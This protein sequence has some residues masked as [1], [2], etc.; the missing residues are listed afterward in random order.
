[1]DDMHQTNSGIGTDDRAK[2]PK[3]SS[4]LHR[5]IAPSTLRCSRE[6]ATQN[7]VLSFWGKTIR[8]DDSL[9]HKRGVRPMRQQFKPLVHHLLDVAAVAIQL[10]KGNHSLLH[11]EAGD[12]GVAPD[13]LVR[14]YA[15]L[16]SLHDIGKFSK[17]FQA[18]V[19]SLWPKR[20]LGPLQEHGGRP[21]WRNTAIL[22]RTP[23]LQDEFRMLFPNVVKDDIVSIIAAVS[24]H[25]GK[26]PTDNDL[27]IR[28][29]NALHDAQIGRK[30]VSMSY[31]AMQI[32]K[33]F[34]QPLPI[35]E[36]RSHKRIMRWSWF[37]SGFITICDW[38]GSDDIYFRFHESN[39]PIE[40]YWKLANNYAKQ[41]L[42]SKGLI[43]SVPIRRPTYSN[44]SPQIVGRLRPM[45]EFVQKIELANGPQLFILEDT[46]GSGKTEAAIMLAARMM[47]ARKGEGIYFALPTMATANAM[48][49]R[50]DKVYRSLFDDS[51]TPSLALAHG[52]SIITQKLWSM[53]K[54]MRKKS[55]LTNGSKD[56]YS[57][58]TFCAD[59]IADDRRLSLLAEIGAGTIDQAFLAVLP[60][61]FLTLRQ[62]SLAQ[63]I[64]VIDEA[65]CFDAYMGEELSSLIRL[66]IQNNGSIVILSA[67]LACEQRRRIAESFGAAIGL[68]D[69][70]DLGNEIMGTS[71]PM[72]T[73]LSRNG[74]R[75]YCDVGFEESLRREI[76]IETISKRADSVSIAVES[77]KMG[78]CV[79]IICNAVDEAIGVHEHVISTIPDS[80]RVQL[81]HSRFTQCDRQEVEEA[82]L[83]RFARNSTI[84]D[85]RGGI[86][87]AT[88]VVE[89]SLDLDFDLIIT[90]LA[91]IDLLIQRA[92]RLWRHMDVRPKE[93]RPIAGP[94]MVVLT[95]DPFSV[96]DKDWLVSTLGN[97][98]YV[99]RSPGLMW[100]TAK[101]LFERG[102]IRIPDSLRPMIE[103]VYS[104]SDLPH[105][106]QDQEDE[107]EGQEYADRM[108]GDFNV[109]DL[110]DGYG[111]LG[112]NISSNE[113]IGTRL[114]EET[115][116]LRLARRAGEKLV[117]WS[118]G[119]LADSQL[120]WALSEVRVRKN[121][122]A[123]GPTRSARSLFDR[124][125]QG[126]LA[127]LAT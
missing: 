85:R 29:S 40:R 59:W 79:L 125:S 45:Q 56:H 113:D 62:F 11:R 1:M 100:R 37:L 116:T 120:D 126:R 68:R 92:G 105:Q 64:L 75:E 17:G 20:I 80:S 54:K 107:A 60:K 94:R 101:I 16:S 27:S 90:D 26:P 2:N 83:Q 77:A 8:S 96:E 119:D 21:H 121:F 51:A 74:V 38:V 23:P 63:R 123:G 65:H 102:L 19:P 78:A 66:H 76:H 118:N 4:G 127:N 98:S 58:S 99:Y 71:F 28:S 3:R 72:L 112:S 111:S 91:P 25:H 52:R 7:Q 30:C 24:G 84:L 122:L 87:V 106:L 48:Y 97:A 114:G 53:R 41:A 46:T 22:L 47:A 117:S 18:I 88:Q 49:R 82:V 13:N 5:S 33:H 69:P 14:I 42:Y 10:R 44:F 9:S 57:V 81:F 61:K 95:P 93:S 50:L 6:D 104:T 36:I 31:E 110:E 35:K 43:P 124:S 86:L 34:I 55:L 115:I 67:T 32:L 39:I 108:L 103:F 12:L 70:E 89:Q 109:V 15:F 73:S